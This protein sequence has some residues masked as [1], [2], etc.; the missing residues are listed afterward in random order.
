M[1]FNTN[2][3]VKA[4]LF[5]AFA[6]ILPYIFHWT[7]VG[8]AALLPM[9]IP[10]LLCGFFLGSQYGILVGLVAPLLNSGLT[11]MPPIFPTAVSMAFELAA[12]GF[13]A[14]FFY[15][16]KRYNIYISLI[17]SMLIGRVVLGIANYIILFAGGD[18]FVLSA[19]LASA[20]VNS[21]WGIVIQLV[22]IPFV[23]RLFESNKGLKV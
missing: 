16:Q 19:F 23:V 9:H 4:A 2:N 20:F 21:M 7:G 15:K 10:V 17:L 11:G 6:I 12:Y 8:G 1:K 14:G 13:F 5:L 18:R 3:V 22:L